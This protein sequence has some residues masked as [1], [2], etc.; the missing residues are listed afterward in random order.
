MKTIP[1]SPPDITQ[2]EIN[3]VSDVL[4]SGWITTGP[5]TKRFEAELAAFCN[6]SRMVC[7][8]SATAAEECNLRVLGIREGDEVIVP[9]YTYTS[10]ASAALHAG[11]RVIFADIQPDGD[12]VTHSPEMDYSLV[13]GFI[14]ARTKAI[15]PVDMAGIMCDYDRLKQLAEATSSRFRP[16]GKIQEAIGRVAIVSDSAHALGATRLGKTAGA[17][18]GLRSFHLSASTQSRT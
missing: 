11:A 16:S 10:T 1:F 8:N 6:T 18:G 2:D 15:I 17:G 3:A 4:R 13:E 9:A 5:A 7:L 14:T 12:P